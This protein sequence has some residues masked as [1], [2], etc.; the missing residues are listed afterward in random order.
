M[1]LTD[2]ITPILPR[3]DVPSWSNLLWVTLLAV[4]IYFL[5]RM[6]L[7]RIVGKIIRKSQNQLDD[8][9]L[10]TRIFN[11]T[12]A[13]APALIF[14]LSIPLIPGPGSFLRRL[15][16]A[17]IILIIF[18]ILSSLLTVLEKIYSKL[19]LSRRVPMKSY[20]QTLR[21]ILVIIGLILVISTVLGRS[22]LLL[23]SG[24]GALTAVLMLIF[25]DTILSFVAS[26]QI[27]GND[28]L[29]VG[30][31]LAVPEF[32]ADGDVIDIALHHVKIQNWD[33]TISTIP[34]HALVSSSF[35]NW[36]FMTE[37]G[38]R[39]IKR[40]VFIDLTS[41]KFCTAEMLER[42][43]RFQLLT[44]YTR[45]K[46][47]E[48]EAYNKTHNVDT[49]STVN[50]RRLTNI[51]TFRSYVTFYLQNHPDIH[52]N[53][54][55]MVRQL[56]PSDR[57]LPLEIYAF[58]KDTRWVQYEAIQ[59]DIF[60]HILAVIPE[61]ELRIFQNPTGLDFQQLQRK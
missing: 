4:L 29:S 59:A 18:L 36:R 35:K 19:K 25:R 61:F 5:V 40:S 3:P 28:L 60:D 53:M 15:L 8:V 38:G 13:L 30:D 22:P 43:E 56:A 7:F 45:R 6:I 2:F 21:I 37:S 10:E 26:I 20:L 55:M 52:K 27:A 49:S 11:R 50:G 23:L 1:Q 32:G 47:A 33:K 57:G 9:I 17:L 51:G 42:F 54:T 12:A 48:L 46:I 34:T 44:D 14:Y 41:V 58:A 16:G 24:I 31:W 39:R